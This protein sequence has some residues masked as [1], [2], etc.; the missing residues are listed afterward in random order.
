MEI[1][2]VIKIYTMPTLTHKFNVISVKISTGSFMECNNLNVKFLKKDR[3]PGIAKAILKRE[4]EICFQML[5]PI[6]KL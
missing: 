3:G 5:K 6:M 1:L 4:G 2:S